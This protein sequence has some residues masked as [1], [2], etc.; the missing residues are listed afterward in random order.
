MLTLFSLSH[1]LG[2]VLFHYLYR[3]DCESP[4]YP[5]IHHIILGQTIYIFG[6]WILFQ[7]LLGT[8]VKLNTAFHPLMDG[9]V[10]RTIKNLEDMLRYSVIYF[11]GSWDE[12][13]PLVE[14]S[15]KNSYH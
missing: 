10:E 14:F 11:N 15:Y 3:S 1:L 13:F 4:W 2:G 6:F 12:Y 5:V 8:R 9:Q 7:N